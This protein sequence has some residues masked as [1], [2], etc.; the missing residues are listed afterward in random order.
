MKLF[1]FNVVTAAVLIVG[2]MFTNTAQ[3]HGPGGGYGCGRVG[4]IYGSYGAY[5]PQVGIYQSYPLTV[6]Y[7]PSTQV[8]YFPSHVS[9]GPGYFGGYRTVGGVSYSRPG[10]TFY[11]GR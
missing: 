11:F 3:A 2:G 7:F 9:C 8:G 1:M 6:G 4:G 5:Y 10:F